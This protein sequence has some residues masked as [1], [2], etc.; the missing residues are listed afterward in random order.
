V[1]VLK[2]GVLSQ[3][4]EPL[5]VSVVQALPSLQSILVWQAIEILAAVN[6]VGVIGLPAKS[7]MKLICGL[8]KK[9]IVYVP[10][11]VAGTS[12]NKVPP[13]RAV[14]SS[15]T[16]VVALMPVVQKYSKSG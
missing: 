10:A 15:V 12:I 13:Y 7:S 4:L 9:P 11:A 2:F 16:P 8:L 6:V 5:H 14:P 3:R 1:L